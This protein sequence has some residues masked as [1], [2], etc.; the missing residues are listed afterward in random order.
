VNASTA[1]WNQKVIADADPTEVP[2]YQA[3][4]FKDRNSYNPWS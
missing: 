2:Q 4:T 1:Q 3:L